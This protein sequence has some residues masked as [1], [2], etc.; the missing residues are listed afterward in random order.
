MGIM[1]GFRQVL[2]INGVCI[3]RYHAIVS[4]KDNFYA[5]PFIALAPE[6]F[7]EQVS[8]I[9]KNY[10]VINLDTV[11]DC[12]NSGE[13]FPPRCVVFT[14]DDGYKDNF[15]AYKILKKYNATGTFYIAAD[16]IDHKSTLWLFE[17][18]YRIKQTGESSIRLTTDSHELSCPLNDSELRN[19]AIKKVTDLIKS[20]DLTTRENLRNQLRSQTGDV[21][22]FEEKS[23]QVMLT[24]EQVREMS[25]NKMTIAGHTMTHINLPNAQPSEAEAEIVNCK[26]VIED[27]IQKPVHHFSYP[28]GGNYDYYNDSIVKMV[29]SAGYRTSTTSHNG[30]ALSGSNPFELKRL[31][32]TD[33]IS[34]L[35]YQTDMEYHLNRAR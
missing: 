7:E 6:L 17:V 5:S 3:L 34:E 4:R 25:E 1:K 16:C 15:Y 12:L 20:N 9:S 23:S 24:W 30:I 10:R 18:I 13:P 28:N 14:F 22:D 8:Y 29:K 31:R 33:H 26:N 2:P 19:T 11:A 35:I 27:A 21:T 32:I